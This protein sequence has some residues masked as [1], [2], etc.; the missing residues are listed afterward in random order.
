MTASSPQPHIRASDDCSPDAAA[1]QQRE[2]RRTRRRA[3][4][5]LLGCVGAIA[6]LVTA[7]TS[8]RPQEATAQ[9]ERTAANV[10]QLTVINPETAREIARLYAD[11]RYHCDRVTCD[12]SPKARNDAAHARLE[13][14][15]RRIGTGARTEAAATISSEEIVPISTG[16][17]GS[18]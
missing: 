4:I 10:E 6:L 18:R 16:S 8:R 5:A 1:P 11:S 2:Q 3:L 15:M 9:I 17:I 13:A 7:G 14:A 12:A